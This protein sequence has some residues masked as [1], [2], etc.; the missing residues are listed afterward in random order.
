VKQASTPEYNTNR[1]LNR[2]ARCYR[3]YS[4][5]SSKVLNGWVQGKLRKSKGRG[6][7]KHRLLQKVWPRSIFFLSENHGVTLSPVVIGVK[8][9]RK[10]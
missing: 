3:V 7:R 1:F 9:L 8:A 6:V 10:R 4:A 2:D 5:G